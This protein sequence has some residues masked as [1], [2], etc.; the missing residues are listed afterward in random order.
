M[1]QSELESQIKVAPG[2][3]AGRGDDL[4]RDLQRRDQRPG[5]GQP[6]RPQHGQ[7]VRHEPAGPRQLPRS[8]R[9]RCSCKGAGGEGERDYSE[10]TARE[11]DVEV[12]KIIDDATEEV[13]EV[14]LDAPRG[15]GGDRPAADREGSHRR[16]A[17]CGSCWSSTFPDRGLC[18]VRRLCMARRPRRKLPTSAAALVLSRK[19]R[20]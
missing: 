1:T 9:G 15:A 2:R 13:R 4:P 12:R 19:Y 14:L 16:R 6:H 5:T 10:R 11:I 18:P 3:H 17:S 7:G 8:G 20:R